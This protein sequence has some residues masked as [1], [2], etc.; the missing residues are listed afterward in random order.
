M[1][2]AV[3]VFIAA[4]LVFVSLT[5]NLLGSEKE[6]ISNVRILFHGYQAPEKNGWGTAG[7]LVAGNI[8][9]QPNMWMSILGTRYN[10]KDWWLEIMIGAIVQGGSET[11]LL[12]IRFSPPKFSK[13]AGSW[14]NAQWRSSG[15]FYFYGR[16]ECVLSKDI[17]IGP[18]TENLFDRNKKDDVSIG[19]YIKVPLGK[20]FTAV[21][22]YQL[23][24]KGGNQVWFRALF[25]F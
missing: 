22:A 14:W 3:S 25:N 12:D 4:L 8:T 13:K 23:H 24:K 15:R 2:Q 10:S 20:I 1:R 21:N 18:E 5:A 7:W 11:P 19:A 6:T 17:S 9:N 16:L